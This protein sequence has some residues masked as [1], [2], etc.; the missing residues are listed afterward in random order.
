MTTTVELTLSRFSSSGATTPL[1]VWN[2]KQSCTAFARQYGEKLEEGRLDFWDIAAE[3]QLAVVALDW[4]GAERAARLAAA[5][6]PSEWMLAT[7]LR[8][9]RAVGQTFADAGDRRRLE[10]VLRPPAAGRCSRGRA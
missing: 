7:T 3:L 9:V 4:P 2:L 6:A 5:Q 10:D 8:D 1:C